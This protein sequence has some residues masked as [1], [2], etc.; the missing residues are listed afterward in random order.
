MT[1]SQAI[2]NFMYFA[3]N[4][5]PN[6]LRGMFAATTVPTHL[7]EK[8]NDLCKRRGLNGTQGIFAWFMELS[9]NN[10]DLVCQYVSDNYSY[11]S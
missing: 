6:Q 7:E 9:Q 1:N 3:Y 5:T 10:K 11:K 8:F 4:F 2:T